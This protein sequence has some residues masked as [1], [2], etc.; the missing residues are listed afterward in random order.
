MLQEVVWLQDMESKINYGVNYS[1]CDTQRDVDYS[2]KKCYQDF[3]KIVDKA[4]GY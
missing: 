4:G 1:L 2:V 3:M